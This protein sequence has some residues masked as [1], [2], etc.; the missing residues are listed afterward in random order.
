MVT[1]RR[2]QIRKTRKYRSLLADWG[3]RT[4]GGHERGPKFEGLALDPATYERFATLSWTAR[5]KS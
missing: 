5:A 3:T 1:V 2:P 4:L